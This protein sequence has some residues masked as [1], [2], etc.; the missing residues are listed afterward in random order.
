MKTV[1]CN[2]Q[3]YSGVHLYIF[4]TYDI[5]FFF[6][7]WSKFWRRNVHS[8]TFNLNWLNSTQTW[9][10]TFEEKTCSNKFAKQM[11]FPG[12]ELD[13][14]LVDTVKETIEFSF[15]FSNFKEFHMNLWILFYV[16]L[17][18]CQNVHLSLISSQ[19]FVVAWY[20]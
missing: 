5:F 8:F 20:R 12:N 3:T 14:W 2:L 17:F 1:L 4:F 6:F 10:W 19:I 11:F 15:C 16:V 18:Y 13:S 7:Y 9:N